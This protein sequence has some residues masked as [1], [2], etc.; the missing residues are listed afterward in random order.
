[1]T[2]NEEAR[3]EFCD[4]VAEDHRQEIA[5][6]DKA[7]Y[8]NRRCGELIKEKQGYVRAKKQEIERLKQE[9]HT[10]EEHLKDYAEKKRKLEQ[11]RTKKSGMLEWNKDEWGNKLTD[12]KRRE[13]SNR[14]EQ[15]SNTL[16]SMGDRVWDLRDRQQNLKWSKSENETELRELQRRISE[17]KDKAANYR[18][19]KSR[20]QERK[21]RFLDK[22]REHCP[23]HIWP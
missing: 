19:Q 13:L 7:E 12:A 3:R 8:E 10:V 4:E 11:E 21:Q 20:A 1:M 2:L 5:A 6:I 18:E 15:I 9:M 23:D 22:L 16:W 17:L 14:V